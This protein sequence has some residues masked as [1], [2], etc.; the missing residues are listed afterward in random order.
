MQTLGNVDRSARNEWETSQCQ[1][2]LAVPA[3]GKMDEDCADLSDECML[4]SDSDDHIVDDHEVS[5]FLSVKH[6]WSP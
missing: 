1:D 6:K 3:E 2:L 4:D 5:D